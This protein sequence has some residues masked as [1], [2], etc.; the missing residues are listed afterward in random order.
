MLR[1][2][3]ENPSSAKAQESGTLTLGRSDYSGSTNQFFTAG[4]KVGPTTGVGLATKVT[5]GCSRVARQRSS[6][7]DEAGR[8]N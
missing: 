1:I 4:A 2:V 7:D 6:H 3:Q 8:A 5:F